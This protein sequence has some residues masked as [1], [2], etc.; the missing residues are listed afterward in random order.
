MVVDF[1]VKILIELDVSATFSLPH[2]QAF[3]DWTG[4][5]ILG[6]SQPT[7]SGENENKRIIANNITAM[8]SGQY[9]GGCRLG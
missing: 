7:R 1:P 9:G 5:T 4:S 6:E 3:L 8:G 2:T